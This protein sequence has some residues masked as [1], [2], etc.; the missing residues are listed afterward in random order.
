MALD[1]LPLFEAEAK[2]RKQAAGQ[3]HG[4]GQE[5]VVA[6][7]PPPIKEKSRDQ[8][9]SEFGV[10]PRY[11]TDAKRIA[12]A[13]PEVL[14][15]VRTGAINIPTAK[16]P[17]SLRLTKHQEKSGFH[18]SIV[19]H[20]KKGGYRFTYCGRVKRHTGRMCAPSVV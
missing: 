20:M 19:R 17:P 2:D 14:D 13:A 7:M 10:A 16:T 6:T 5:K 4:R 3:I 12:Q 11:V 15:K 9:A 1:A 8:A 18:I